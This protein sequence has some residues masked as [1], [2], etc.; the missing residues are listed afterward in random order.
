MGDMYAQHALADKFR[1]TVGAWVAGHVAGWMCCSVAR[2]RSGTAA[3]LTVTL[4]RREA[5]K[6]SS[7]NFQRCVVEERCV[8]KKRRNAELFCPRDDAPSKKDRVQAR[9]TSCDI[10]SIDQARYGAKVW[11][12]SLVKKSVLQKMHWYCDTLC[13]YAAVKA[14]HRK[15]KGLRGRERGFTDK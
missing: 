14:D 7:L 1:G 12:L 13:R 6:E 10:G 9:I 5:R 2:K 4:Q 8:A 15:I 11:M 3:R